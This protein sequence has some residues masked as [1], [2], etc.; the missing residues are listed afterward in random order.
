LSKDKSLKYNGETERIDRLSHY[1]KIQQ[2]KMKEGSYDP[3]KTKDDIIKIF[4]EEKMSV[5]NILQ[6]L[7]KEQVTALNK[8]IVK[9][10]FYFFRKLLRTWITLLLMLLI[11]IMIRL[12]KS[13]ERLI[14]FIKDLID[15]SQRLWKTLIFY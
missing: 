10:F 6:N 11:H 7:L 8:E 12:M 4:K 14:S 2:E 9:I 15:I 13:R 5:T 3:M 1:L